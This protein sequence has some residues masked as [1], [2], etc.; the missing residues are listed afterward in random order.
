V[1]CRLR[2]LK[3]FVI[4]RIEANLQQISDLTHC[5]KASLFSLPTKRYFSLHRRLPAS[6]TLHYKPWP[7][8]IL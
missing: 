5:P 2:Q 4:D 1:G 7:S 6:L 3:P 8:E